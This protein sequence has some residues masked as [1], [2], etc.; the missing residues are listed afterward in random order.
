[1]SLRAALFV[2]EHAKGLVLQLFSDKMIRF[3][4]IWRGQLVGLFARQFFDAPVDCTAILQD[5]V[6]QTHVHAYSLALL[7]ALKNSHRH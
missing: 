1:M 6:P 3:A 2:W 7:S 4:C 5:P